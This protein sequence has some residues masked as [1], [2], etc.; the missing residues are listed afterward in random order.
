MKRDG[1]RIPF[2]ES[3]SYPIRAGN[4]V[5]PLVDGEPAFRRICEAVESARSSVWLTVAFLEPGFEMPG[6]RD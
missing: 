2:I 3:G 6:G 1:N 4:R 5:T